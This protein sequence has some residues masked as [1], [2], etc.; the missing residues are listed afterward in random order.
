MRVMSGRG[1]EILKAS[2]TGLMPRRS[3]SDRPLIGLAGRGF[4]DRLIGAW[5]AIGKCSSRD[6]A[7]QNTMQKGLRVGVCLLSLSRS[8]G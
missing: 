5:N 6:L 8:G 1:S 7:D 4:R 3:R 2:G